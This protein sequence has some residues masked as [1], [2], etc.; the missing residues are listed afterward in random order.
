VIV[1][2]RYQIIIN[3]TSMDS[4]T[5]SSIHYGNSTVPIDENLTKAKEAKYH[6]TELRSLDGLG[7]LAKGCFII[8]SLSKMS[9]PAA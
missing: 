8:L 7:R 4:W 2:I 3:P 9:L 6:F 5:G 1:L